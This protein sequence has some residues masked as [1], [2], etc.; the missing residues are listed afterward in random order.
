[1]R[2]Q[3]LN[4]LRLSQ[5]ETCTAYSLRFVDREELHLVQITYLPT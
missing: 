5:D 2:W 3:T 1:M 4:L